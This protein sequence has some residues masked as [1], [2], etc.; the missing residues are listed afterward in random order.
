ML[1]ETVDWKATIRVWHPDLHMLAG[2]TSW[3]SSCLC[4]YLIKTVHHQMPVAVRKWLYN[5]CYFGVLCLLC[6]EVE[7]SDYVFMCS[8]DME[9]QRKIL[10]VVSANWVFFAESCSLS[11]S[12][13]LQSL[14][15]CFL[16]IGLYSVLCKGFVLRDW[17]AE[18]IKVL[19]SKKKAVSVVVG[20]VGCFV[21][22]YRSKT[23]LV[24]SAYRVKMEAAGLVGNDMLIFGL[25][26]CINSLLS[27]K[28]V[29]MLGIIS[30][31]AVSFGR[32]RSCL[33]F[34]GLDDNPCV[35]LGV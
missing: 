3:R 7:L 35:L 11:S 20:F 4:T 28:V 21:E 29:R 30:S 23:W 14:D 26:Y 1:T 2:F 9:I 31:F 34:S 22:L 27:G 8:C 13:V 18:A 10:A 5:K 6:H 32:C 16:D 24:R 19:E 25:S 17:C 12:A 33:L 15:Q